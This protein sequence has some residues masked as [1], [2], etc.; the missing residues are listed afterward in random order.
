MGARAGQLMA[1]SSSLAWSA[2]WA[3]LVEVTSPAV[4]YVWLRQSQYHKQ[5]CKDWPLAFPLLLCQKQY[6]EA[7]GSAAI[8]T[9]LGVPSVPA[10]RVPIL[11]TQV[12][13]FL[14]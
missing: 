14:H 8:L 10:L 11:M 6:P 1:D 3:R 9:A 2:C 5:A 7:V 13:M 12:R 4:S